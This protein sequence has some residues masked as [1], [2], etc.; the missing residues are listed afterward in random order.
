MHDKEVK[1]CFFCG[2]EMLDNENK[3]NHRSSVQNNEWHQKVSW[4]GGSYTGYIKDG[5]PHGAGTL[6]LPGGTVCKGDW[7]EG[8][9]LGTAIVYYPSGGIYEGE[10]INGKRN[11]YG[12]YTYPNG[13]KLQGKWENNHFIE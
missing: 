10:L 2:E 5:K 8:K 13:K 4:L 11:G 12:T 3:C 1:K 6:S 9:P 7:V